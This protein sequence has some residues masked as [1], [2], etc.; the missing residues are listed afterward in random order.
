MSDEEK[1]KEL[2]R[3]N[4][5]LININENDEFEISKI[6][7]LADNYDPSLNYL[8]P[9]NVAT[10]RYD[11]LYYISIKDEGTFLQIEIQK[12]KLVK[13]VK[14]FK[15]KTKGVAQS[16]FGYAIIQILNKIQEMKDKINTNIAEMNN[17]QT[18]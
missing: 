7:E 6:A 18:P 9:A 16:A 5:G 10:L 13:E 2:S 14:V 17:L 1:I 8:D 12:Q 3:E 15:I 11:D 4:V